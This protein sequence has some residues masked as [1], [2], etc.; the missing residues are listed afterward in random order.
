MYSVS[1]YITVVNGSNRII[2]LL[3]IC[4]FMTFFF[5]FF[6]FFFFFFV[7]SFLF[8]FVFVLIYSPSF[9]LLV[10]REDCGSQLWYFLGIY[11]Y[12][13]AISNLFLA[14]RGSALT[15]FSNLFDTY[16]CLRNLTKMMWE[17]ETKRIEI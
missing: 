15:I 3:C 10:P 4:D 12:S 7:F 1:N 17:T 16:Q 11:T 13:F 6:L 14:L 2:F 9:L 5:F 8:V